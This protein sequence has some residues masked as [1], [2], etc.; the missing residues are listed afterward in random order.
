MKRSFATADLWIL[1]VPAAAA[2]ILDPLLSLADTLFVATL[3]TEAVAA[4]AINS[5][6]FYLVSF[7][8]VIASDA[9]DLPT[10][11][12]PVDVGRSILYEYACLLHGSHYAMAPGTA[13]PSSFDKP[14]TNSSKWLPAGGD[15]HVRVVIAS[16]ALNQTFSHSHE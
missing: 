3:G 9:T 7:V 10:L 15:S 6:I 11:T 4:L 1:A 13:T 8:F 5:A 16:G 2:N 12:G 14:R